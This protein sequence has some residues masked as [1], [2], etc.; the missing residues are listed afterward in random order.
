M[1]AG[2]GLRAPGLPPQGKPAR[3][4]DRARRGASAPR[5][6]GRRA[7]PR[8]SVRAGAIE[9][10]AASWTRHR[11]LRE[12]ETRSPAC[13]GERTQACQAATGFCL[14]RPILI[15]AIPPPSLLLQPAQT[16]E[17]KGRIHLGFAGAGRC[18]AR[19]PTRGP[20]AKPRESREPA[21]LTRAWGVGAA[22]APEEPNL[23]R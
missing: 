13:S 10:R 22:R 6:T 9:A 21:G 4:G 7:K 19:F 16:K 2:Q 11:G 12:A 18:G 5:R 15:S 1:T 20:G 23:E 17:S 14:L 3:S 8:A